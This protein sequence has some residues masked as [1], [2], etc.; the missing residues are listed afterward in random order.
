MVTYDR[1]QIASAI[2]E[3]LDGKAVEELRNKFNSLQAIGWFS[4]D[5]LLP[6]AMAR[7]IYSSFPHPSELRE[8]KSLRERKYV[9]SQMDQYDPQAEEAVFAFHS[10]EVLNKI[11]AITN[12]DGLSADQELYAGGISLMSKGGFLN[13]HLD[14]SH[15]NRRKLYR[16][17]NLLYYCS[18]DWDPRNGGNLELWPEGV[19]GSPIVVESLFNRLVVMTTGGESWHSVSPIT[20]INPRCCVSNYYFSPTPLGG[21]SYSRV[22]SFRGRPDQPVRDLAL[23]IDARLRQAIR[24]VRPSGLVA[25][26]HFYQR[27]RVKLPE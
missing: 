4:I 17:L 19:K 15:D 9:T 12:I 23:R 13:P 5:S 1:D 25:T 27:Q 20:T 2:I 18:P 21:A 6:E 3:R 16:A 14:N 22:T 11:F 8:R 26:T 10:P 24:K 7:A